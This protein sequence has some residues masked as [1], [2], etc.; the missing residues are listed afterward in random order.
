MDLAGPVPES[1]HDRILAMRGPSETILKAHPSLHRAS[2]RAVVALLEAIALWESAPVR[3]ALVVD[4]GSPP[5]PSTS[6][7]RDTFAC[8]ASRRRSTGGSGCRNQEPRAAVVTG[9]RAS[10]TSRISVGF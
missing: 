2:R 3:A 10:E 1:T 5:S 4:D 7:Y 6:L 9:S 8:S